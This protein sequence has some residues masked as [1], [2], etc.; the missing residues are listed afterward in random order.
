MNKRNFLIGLFLLAASVMSYSQFIA[1]VDGENG[2]ILRLSGD[3]TNMMT[4]G[5]QSEEQSYF[6]GAGSPAPGF[7]YLDQQ[8]NYISGRNGY[9]SSI[10]F[11]IHYH[12]VSNIEIYMKLLAQYRPGSPYMPLQ[13]EDHSAKTFDDF[14]VDSAFGRVNVIEGLGL[15]LP[16]D[17][18]LKAGKFDTTPSHFNRVSRYG[19]D[20]VM[21]T[22]KTMNR[23]AFQVQSVYHN[24]YD[25]ADSIS[26]T[27]TTLMRLNEELPE[28]FDEDL[29]STIFHGHETGD[30]VLPVHAALT[31][32]NINTPL[33]GLSLEVLYAYNAMHI[34]SGHSFGLNT[35]LKLP[36][37]SKLSIPVG[38]GAIFQEKN[39]DVLAGTSV[40][41]DASDYTKLYTDGG[42]HN[43]NDI[44]TKSLR[45][46]MRIGVGIGAHYD[47]DN[48]RGEL[49]L[50]FSVNNIAHIYRQ[51]LSILSASCDFRL[52]YQNRYFIGG[53]IYLG[54]LQ[55]LYWVLKPGITNTQDI[56]NH[57]FFLTENLGYEVFMG[58]QMERA[59]FLIGY[60]CAKGL[61]M[62][63]SLEALPETQIKYRQAGTLTESG[64]FERGG[65]FTKLVF[66]W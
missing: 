3:F 55:D 32:R 51:T 20:S 42:Y 24:P 7:Y 27:L 9:Y 31:F 64:L 60:N 22:L 12:P 41:R 11:N 59:R 19:A 57:D 46:A 21:N 25:F 15:D 29:T 48:I 5:L 44:R 26:L 16:L 6:A 40:S 65:I 47:D 13:L 23:Y 37:S 62:S 53:G 18:Y 66:S 45:Q 36:V 54:T 34:H 14:A 56:S 28:F 58:L 61:A 4:L 63:N 10:S 17:V 1:Q 2:P 49:N 33:G 52:T 35:G 30:T 43:P 39:I 38:F 8:G 50:G